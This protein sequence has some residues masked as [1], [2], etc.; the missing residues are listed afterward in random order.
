VHFS[1][2]NLSPLLHTSMD[3]P[4]T[5]KRMRKDDEP[6]PT[7]EAEPVSSSASVAVS[8]QAKKVRKPKVA[9]AAAAAG[10]SKT[11]PKSKAPVKEKNPDQSQPSSAIVDEEDQADVIVVPPAIALLP[12][13][14]ADTKTMTTVDDDAAAAAAAAT[15]A[16]AVPSP[17]VSAGIAGANDA[18]GQKQRRR[19]RKSKKEIAEE[20]A[21]RQSISFV[22]HAHLYDLASVAA[23]APLVQIYQSRPDEYELEAR[24]GI[25]QGARFQ[26]GVTKEFFAAMLPLVN[27]AAGGWDKADGEKKDAWNRTTDIV[28]HNGVRKTK[29]WDEKVE[30]LLRVTYQRKERLADIDFVH[31]QSPDATEVLPDVRVSLKREVTLAATDP[32]VTSL[33]NHQ[34]ACVRSKCRQSFVSKRRGFRVDFTI[35]W[36]G[37]NEERLKHAATRG[38]E[39]WEIELE[40]MPSL[41]LVPQQQQQQQQPSPALLMQH[42]RKW[43]ECVQKLVGSDRPVHLVPAGL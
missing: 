17:L 2:E 26:G 24:V 15:A 37:I 34:I 31:L 36:T 6:A 27:H 35:V 29:Y 3:T 43:F 28:Y 11:K 22:S 33:G 5:R 38:P 18:G 20:E 25:F 4:R 8:P 19:G 10:K 23:L 40:C 42:A 9:A 14:D 30:N 12:S 1:K 13:I 16:T 41:M 32:D 7:T 39:A 21:Q